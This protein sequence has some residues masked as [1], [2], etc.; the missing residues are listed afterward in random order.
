MALRANL[1]GLQA[2]TYKSADRTYDIVVKL[3]EQ[4]GKDQV[5]GFLFPGAPGRTV[6]LTSLGEVQEELAPVQIIRKNKQ[7]ISKLFANLGPALP[8]GT[9][10]SRLSAA[11][12]DAQLLPIGF[13]YGFAGRYEIMTEGQAELAEAGLI[14]ILLVV[15]TLAAILESFKQP[16][17]ILV[18]LPLTLI[19]VFWSL[20][21]AGRSLEIF[22]IMGGVMLIGI[23]VNNAILIMD[24]FNVH[25]RAGLPRHQAM[26]NAACERLRPIVMIT[27]AAV[28][29]MLPLALG[30]G[31]GAEMRNAIGIASAGGILVSGVLTGG[32]RPI[33]SAL[34]TRRQ[35]AAE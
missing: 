31:I 33:L 8:L 2:G 17:L 24:Q 10:V 6:L 14:A 1:E 21:L 29:G 32:G 26:V 30:R 27:L 28:L 25:V 35:K 16:V 5:A 11:I 4:P 22:V 9:A 7:R 19:G 13:T 3:D 23:V 12:D 18:T 15:L 34:F 20:A